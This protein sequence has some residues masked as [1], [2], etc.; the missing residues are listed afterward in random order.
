MPHLGTGTF[1]AF[2]GM[3]PTDQPVTYDMSSPRLVAGLIALALAAAACSSE[4]AGVDA[5]TA[6]N[7]TSTDSERSN[8]TQ[9]SA[10]PVD[11]R[12]LRSTDTDAPFDLSGGATSGANA[13]DVRA[14]SIEDL[15]DDVESLIRVWDTDWGRTTIDY[16]D[17]LAGIP[18]ADPRDAIP[19]ID[20]PVFESPS[21][22]AEWLGADEP[23]ALVQLNGEARFYP[24]SILTA[25]EIVNDRF[26]DV[27]VAVTY[28]P[29]CNT[30]LAFDRRI[31][32]EVIRLGVSGLLRNSDMVMWD[33][34]TTS[35]WQQITG[36]GIAGR[37][38][39]TQLELVSTQIVSFSQFS[40]NFPDGWSLSRDTGFGGRS[41]GR[42]PY[43]GYSSS[44]QPF[45]FDG[46]PDPRFPALE[47][48]VGVITDEGDKSYPF[49]LL[50]AEVV[51]NDVAGDA[52]V[53]VWWA[54]GTTDALDGPSIADSKQIG[55]AVAY[56]RVLDDGTELTFGPGTETG[57]FV[58]DQ[59]GST[60]TLFGLATDGDMA[61]TQLAQISHRN[62]F[63]F[64]WAAF[65]PDG[66]VYGA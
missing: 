57:T 41:Y 22:A 15:P 37:F 58:D 1:V 6:P 8:E 35:L 51:I 44:T 53:V 17:L 32:G 60:W 16:G 39:G 24:L 64:A 34:Q 56:L 65:F 38:A 66:A 26:G 61:G 31:D 18:R 3:Q 62:E 52:P 59:T 47:R 55:T 7:P 49:S 40:E 2:G 48:V 30:A 13:D 25:H 50:E 42:N 4:S 12:I 14:A 20:A 36:E 43:V 63:W 11:E 21:A 10:G 46:E 33:D 45:L 54:P 28:C 27:P 19:P 9:D 29:L 23:G 5:A